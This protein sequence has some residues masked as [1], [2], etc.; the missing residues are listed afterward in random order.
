MSA[1][2]SSITESSEEDSMRPTLGRYFLRLLLVMGL[3]YYAVLVFDLILHPLGPGIAVNGFS[4]GEATAER[5]IA[6]LIGTGDDRGRGPS[7]E[8]DTRESNRLS[9]DYLGCGIYWL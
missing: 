6:V 5:Y 3:A 1:Q 8:A 7:H 9:H 4:L 2:P